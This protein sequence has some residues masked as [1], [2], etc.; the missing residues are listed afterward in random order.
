MTH[1]GL[2]ECY[3]CFFREQMP[4]QPRGQRVVGADTRLLLYA[5]RDSSVIRSDYANAVSTFHSPSGTTL[6]ACVPGLVS[7]VC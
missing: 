2:D 1:F 6:D 4:F 5:G 3:G 7:H